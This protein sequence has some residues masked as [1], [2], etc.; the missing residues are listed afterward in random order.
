[1]TWFETA[2]GILPASNPSYH[3]DR[4]TP[5]NNAGDGPAVMRG[6]AAGG[7]LD[8][9]GAKHGVLRCTGIPGRAHG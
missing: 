5:R 8:V 4:F 3:G 2:R 9:F 1:M 7:E 6:G